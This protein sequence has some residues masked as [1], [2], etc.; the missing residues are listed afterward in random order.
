MENFI[1]AI[2][3]WQL[4]MINMSFVIRIVTNTSGMMTIVTGRKNSIYYDK[5]FLPDQLVL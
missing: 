5:V 3:V 4:N 2:M 1:P